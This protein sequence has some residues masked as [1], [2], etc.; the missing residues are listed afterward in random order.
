MANFKKLPSL[1]V[2]TAGTLA[3]IVWVFVSFEFRSP[4]FAFLINWLVMSWV[5]MLGQFVT[6]PSLAPAYY[7]IKPFEQAGKFYERLGIRLFKKMVRRGPFAIFSPTLRFPEKK[8]VPALENY[9]LFMLFSKA[10]WMRFYGSYCSI[11]YSTAT[12]SC[13]NDIIA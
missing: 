7:E 5:A 8:T 10:G 2:I 3:L 9:R 4:T 6:F 13:S 1:I 11:S 12:P